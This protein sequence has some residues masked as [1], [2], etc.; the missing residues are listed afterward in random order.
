VKAHENE[1]AR[2]EWR[3][4]KHHEIAMI[5]W[6]EGDAKAAEYHLRKATEINPTKPAAYFALA[7]VLNQTGR[8]EEASAAAK[9]GLTL[10]PDEPAKLVESAQYYLHRY[11]A[12]SPWTRKES[13]YYALQAAIATEYQYLPAAEI[14]ADA[15]AA[16]GKF[17]EA[18][19]T[20]QKAAATLP[21]AER[22][23][24]QAPIQRAVAYRERR[25]A[26]ANPAKK[27]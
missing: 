26:K 23:A 22:A 16:N 10:A 9:K 4:M 14:L 12:P 13:L 5:Y 11:P 3:G 24:W 2:T 15:Y 8:A 17:R 25:H 1:P 27:L 19:A 7:M 20:I 6:I 21:A 18:N